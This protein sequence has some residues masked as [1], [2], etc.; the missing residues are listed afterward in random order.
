MK[1]GKELNLRFTNT[2][3]ESSNTYPS[4]NVKKALG[5]RF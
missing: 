2:G 3:L 4:G 1:V 5:A